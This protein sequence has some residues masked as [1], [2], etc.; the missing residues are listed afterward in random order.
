[1]K[2]WIAPCV[3]ISLALPVMIG[4]SGGGDTA[5]LPPAEP[6]PSSEDQY[7][8]RVRDVAQPQTH[9]WGFY[10]VW[11][12]VA[13]REIDFIPARTVM[14]E[15]NVVKLLNSNPAD[16]KFA[17]LDIVSQPTY[18]DVDLN[19]SLSHPFPGLDQYKGYD[20]RGVFIGDGNGIMNY[21]SSLKYSVESVDQ[22]MM[23][24]PDDED[25]GGPDGYTRWFN[26][27]EF[28]VP[29]LFGYTEGAFATDHYTGTATVNPYK[30]YAD[31]LSSHESAYAFVSSGSGLGNN[32]FSAGATNTR[33]FYIR[34]P[35]PY[36][37]IV[38][39]YAI[40]ATWK[41]DQHAD[42]PANTPEVVAQTGYTGD[43]TLY[44]VDAGNKGGKLVA[45]F[46]LA[47][48]GPQPDTI[49]VESI[50]FNDVKEFESD[51][52]L[53]PGCGETYS[54]YH[55]EIP[56]DDIT[57]NNDVDVWLIMEYDEYNYMNEFWVPNDAGGDPLAAFVRMKARVY[58][59]VPA[60]IEVVRPNGGEECVPGSDEE[61]LWDSYDVPGTVMI[62]YSKDNFFAHVKTI[63]VDEPND[64]SFLWQSIPNDPSDTVRV[65]I[66]SN[67]KPWVHDGSDGVFAI[68][69]PKIEVTSPNGGE[70]WGSGR[71][72]EIAWT[73]EHLLGTVS[74]EY[75]KDGFGSD[76]NLIAADEE[77][78][79]SYLWE[80]IPCDLSHTVRVR[81]RSTL[82]EDVSDMSDD[83]LTIYESGGAVTWGDSWRDEGWVVAVDEEGNSYV[84][85][86]TRVTS[87]NDD[88]FLTKY[89][90]CKEELWT[91][92]WGGPAYDYGN[93]IAIDD[94]GNIYVVGGF[95][96]TADFDPGGGQE[97]HS[98]A[99]G[100]DVFLT[101]FDSSGNHF[102]A[103]TWG[104]TG[105]DGAYGVELDSEG[106][107]YVA[108]DFHYS[109]DFDP[110][111]GTDWQSSSGGWDPFLSK[112]DTSGVFQ[113]ADTWG[114][115]GNDFNYGIA[116]D[117]P[118]AIYVTGNFYGLVDFDPSGGVYYKN[119]NGGSDI[120]FSKLDSSGALQWVRAWG[121]SGNDSGHKIGVDGS[122][123]IDIAGYFY[124]SADFDPGSGVDLRVSN[125]G[126]D[127]FVSEFDASGGYQW[128]RTWGGTGS[129]LGYGA[130]VDGDGNVFACGN[131]QYTVDFDPGSGTE[132][133]VSNGSYD[134]F[135]SKLDT[136]GAFEW[137]RAWGGT[138]SDYGY[139]V[140]ANGSGKPLCTGYFQGTA[141]FAPDDPA[142]GEDPDPHTS[143]GSRDI[144][145]S[146]F[147]ADGCW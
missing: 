118:D 8:I 10:T 119:S 121:G 2:L 115:V 84:T 99:G 15:A 90:P 100:I 21:N 136:T 138:S 139:G 62:E 19:V 57:S 35:T 97:Y 25:G 141:D 123:S 80:G 52:V 28:G 87:V 82:F 110:G 6:R 3:A 12:D 9:L 20:V 55:V 70:E 147:L 26:P 81:V 109:V 27:T 13:N 106:Y 128:A 91:V 145:V 111:A 24:D 92:T 45:D 66:R 64:G 56:A 37:K 83:D 33:N 71:D 36:P 30:L 59:Y 140:A 41:G 98:S 14:Y 79:G 122:G 68:L 11:I 113:W 132:E 76:V 72:E 73:S 48:Y 7:S 129:D 39:N 108:G 130:A 53:A 144:F 89:G 114:G 67:A 18:I 42:H 40:V 112:F 50:V 61:V 51:S 49:R 127:V 60:W 104:G 38:F 107:L 86:L 77:N 124:G 63:A 54:T 23:D 74:I 142:C 29:G 146:A 95:S 17:I 143:N 117:G 22:F 4:C 32:V 1:M 135:L 44:Y 88:V 133:R 47:G 120:Y 96:S 125:G 58:D 131:F 16:M 85:G 31:G 116:L 43:S 78:D 93:G 5:I 46:S 105:T 126:Y 94:A 69:Q 134:V 65:R 137:V 34:F 103:R 75:S 101:K 102:W